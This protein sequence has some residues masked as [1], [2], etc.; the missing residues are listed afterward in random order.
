MNRQTFLETL[1]I[2]PVGVFLVRCSSSGSGASGSSTDPAAPPS[3]SGTQDVYSSSDAQ[4]HFHTFGVDDASFTAPPA[5][6]VSGDT[7]TD[8]LHSHTVSISS[9]QLQQVA[10]GQSVMVTTSST[11][12]HTHVFTFVKVS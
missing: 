8:E 7:S 10:T 5:A 11:S 4:S 12:G 3:K 9:D 6:G 2:L 1:L